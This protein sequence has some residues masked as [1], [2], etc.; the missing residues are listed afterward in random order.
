MTTTRTTSGKTLPD[1]LASS[2]LPVPRDGDDRGS[3]DDGDG[4]FGQPR[5]RR[6]RIV[7]LWT[8]D[9][10]VIRSYVT[11]YLI[12]AISF[13]SLYVAVE[14]FTKIH[15]FIPSGIINPTSIS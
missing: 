5:A 7:R 12:C 9:R 6:T 1:T 2:R 14:A 11:A 13:T 3:G 15:R 10:Y 8:L 4:P